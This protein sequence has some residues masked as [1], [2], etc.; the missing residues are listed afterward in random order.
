MGVNTWLAFGTLV[1]VLPLLGVVAGLA[2]AKFRRVP[3]VAAGL[4][5]LAYGVYMAA[6]GVWAVRCWDCRGLSETRGEALTAAALFFGLIAAA[7][8]LGIWLGARLTVVLQRLLHTLRELR[9]AAGRGDASAATDES[10]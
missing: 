5:A 3:V 9:G 10:A 2:R 1:S 7:T 4:V 8:L 6:V